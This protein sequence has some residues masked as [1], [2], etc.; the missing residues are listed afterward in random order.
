MN[1]EL[2]HSTHCFFLIF[3]GE[4][5]P[6]AVGIEN[7]AIALSC[8]SSVVPFFLTF[9]LIRQILSIGTTSEQRG[10]T[11]WQIHASTTQ[12]A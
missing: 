8:C 6:R 3:F 4:E 9:L 2:T 7:F 5:P 12:P 10:G 11:Q 1:L